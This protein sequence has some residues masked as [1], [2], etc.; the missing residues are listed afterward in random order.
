M[1]LFFLE[2]YVHVN[3][4]K[5]AEYESLSKALNQGIKESEP[6]MLLHVQSKVS[7]NEQEV[8][9]KWSEV[10]QS[11]EDLP[12]H[13]Q[14]KHAQE[15]MKKLA[16]GIVTRPVDILAF[17]DWTEEQKAPWREIPGLNVE[18]VP[19]VNGYFR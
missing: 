3:P 12:A 19:L 8:T 14:S 6:G 10:Y 17:C 7:E 11:Y 15:H 18:Y 4:D 9:Y 5:V 2:A 13:L 1:S 16:E